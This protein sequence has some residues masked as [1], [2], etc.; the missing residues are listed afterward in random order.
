MGEL[1]VEEG[2]IRRMDVMDPRIDFYKSE[3]SVPTDPYPLPTFDHGEE[4]YP[5]SVVGFARQGC[6]GFGDVRGVSRVVCL[7]ELMA[8]TGSGI[9]GM[10]FS[11]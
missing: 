3:S 4:P 9:E 2:I 10:I 11:A 1:C 5:R 7:A 8:G 6:L